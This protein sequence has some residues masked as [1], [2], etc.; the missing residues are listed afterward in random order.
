[1]PSSCA[2][3]APWTEAVD[4]ARTNRW[5]RFAGVSVRLTPAVSAGAVV[6]ADGFGRRRS[7]VV[8]GAGD[9]DAATQALYGAWYALRE[10]P[11][12][13]TDPGRRSHHTDDDA[14]LVV[15]KANELQLSV[16]GGDHSVHAATP[17]RRARAPAPRRAS[18]VLPPSSAVEAG[19]GS[20]SPTG[21]DPDA[22]GVTDA[23][24]ESPPSEASTPI[25]PSPY[26]ASFSPTP[27]IVPS[28]ARDAGAVAAICRSVASWKIT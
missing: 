22:G 17:S 24:P 1:M 15:G 18:R 12:V 28:S 19:R 21:A 5:A 2:R 6:C 20:S 23:P 4:G 3:L 11:T 26:F 8:D 27:L 13:P 25:T 7:A 9:A 14:V 10:L 16:L